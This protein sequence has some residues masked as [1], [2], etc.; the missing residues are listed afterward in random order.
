MNIDETLNAIAGVVALATVVPATLN[1]LIYGLGSP[2]WR[3]WLGRALFAKWL[4][5]ALV[6]AFIFARRFFGEFPGYGVVALVLYIFVLLAFTAT[7][8]ELVIERRNPAPPPLPLRKE[9]PMGDLTE[10][11]K[12]IAV[13]TAT[14]PEIWYKTKRVVRTIT[15]ALV[16]LVPIVNLVGL[17]VIGYLN[18][19][20]DVTP[21]SWL[22]A[23]LNGI[24]VATALLM[25]LVARIMA[26][27]GVNAW[28]VRI[29]LG[30][31][32][33]AAVEEGRV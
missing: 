19:Q 25:G 9:H 10:G 22:F 13:T 31:V 33:A 7:T 16:V 27:P 26:V 30:S 18:E 8:V 29:G 32:P 12:H 6:F 21:P 23:A 2:W 24:V 11:G 5:V 3:S 4:A 1:A 15:Q 20:T 28:L 17:A 14:V